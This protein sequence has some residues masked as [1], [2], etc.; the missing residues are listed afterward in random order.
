MHDVESVAIHELSQT[1]CRD[2]IRGTAKRKMDLRMDC[3]AL[4]AAD[5]NVVSKGSKR[6]DELQYVGLATAEI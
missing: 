3:A 6:F 2:Q 4:P 1:N 5:G